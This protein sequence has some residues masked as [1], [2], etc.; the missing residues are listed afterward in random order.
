VKIYQ[1]DL[2]A[3]GRFPWQYYTTTSTIL[4]YYVQYLMIVN[5]LPHYSGLQWRPY[6]SL[7]VYNYID[8]KS[9]KGIGYISVRWVMIFSKHILP[10]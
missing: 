5:L 1:L 8:I 6:I 10:S 7:D 2:S 3:L 4:Q 9:V